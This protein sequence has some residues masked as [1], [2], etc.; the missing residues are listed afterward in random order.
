MHVNARVRGRKGG[1]ER[2]NESVRK[3]IIRLLNCNFL[4]CNFVPVDR[5][6]SLPL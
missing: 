4:S 2:G 5:S 3:K 6:L 1:R